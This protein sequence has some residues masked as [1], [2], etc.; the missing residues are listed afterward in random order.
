MIEAETTPM[1]KRILVALSGTPFTATA[2]KYA[3]ELAK[4]HKAEVTGVTDV[5]IAQLTKVGPVPV[6]GGAAAAS[7]AEHRISVT[8]QHVEQAVKETGTVQ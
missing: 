1:I 7:L 3:L 8:E 4:L 6:G 5:D 2:T